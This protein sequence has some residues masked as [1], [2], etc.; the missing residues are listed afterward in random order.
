MPGVYLLT[1]GREGEVAVPEL[2]LSFLDS[3]LAL[4][5]GD[6]EPVWDSA[7]GGLEEM[8]PVE[9]SVLPDGRDGVVIVVVEQGRRRSHRFVLATDDPPATEAAVR[10]RAIA[11]GLRTRSPRRA[12]SRLL[13]VTVVLA[14]L[15]AMTAL[16]LSAA[17][18]IHF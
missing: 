4:D 7:W 12:V 9:R 5:K 10:E 6:G 11:H 13:L 2:T 8:S 1:E 18:V 3:G 14:A 17:H 16:L 15:A